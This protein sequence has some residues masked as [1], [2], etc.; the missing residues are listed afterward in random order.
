MAR[1]LFTPFLFVLMTTCL[2]MLGRCEEANKPESQL[3]ARRMQLMQQRIAAVL[4]RSGA[5]GFPEHFSD[6]P[7]FRYTDPAR[8]YVAA[9][10][11][12]LGKEGRPLALI[13]TELRPQSFGS[14]RIVYE[15]LSLTPHKF[16]A[17]GGDVAWAPEGSALEFK[18]IPKAPAPG[19][20]AERRL[21]QL[22]AQAK[23]FG[24]NEVV[25]GEKCELRLLPQPIH[26]Y[27]PSQAPY[28]D[29][30]IFLLS[31]GTNPEAALFLESD[32]KQWQYAVGRLAG[33][34]KIAVTIDDTIAWEGPKVRYG[35]SSSYTASNHP[36]D[37]P[38]V[39]PDC[40]QVEDE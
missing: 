30:A 40:K 37:I 7:I 2:P 35:S 16:S 21:T 11:W 15:Y 10:I 6:K 39:S 13:T 27:V 24:G 18:P 26:R 22:R 33:A 29:G 23:R 25:S 14:P 17:T 20:T 34:G 4:V 36:I 12:K 38:G 8:S 3:T 1:I 31:F 19:E 5:D 28:A 9:A 32:G